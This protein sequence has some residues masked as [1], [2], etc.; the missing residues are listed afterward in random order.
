M[1]IEAEAALERLHNEADELA[2][3]GN[4]VEIV[5]DGPSLVHILGQS[6]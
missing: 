4:R 6:D 1:F 5:V 3:S 2:H